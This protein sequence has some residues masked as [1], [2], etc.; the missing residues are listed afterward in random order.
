MEPI[1]LIDDKAELQGTGYFELLPGKYRGQCWNDG[2]VFL[3]EDVFGLV[4][5]IIARHESRFGHYS[6]VEICRLTWEKIIADLQGLAERAKSANDIGEL[7][8]EV[9]FL[10]TPT[11]R[12]FAQEFRA[13][14]EAL[15]RLTMDLSRWLL[16]QL[17][18]HE[19]VSALGI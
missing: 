13:N 4:E 19:C 17:K 15:S 3:A 9:G 18:R 11:E 1:R 14:A 12:E 16:E 10:F 6:F 2:S 8:G 5:P 7:H